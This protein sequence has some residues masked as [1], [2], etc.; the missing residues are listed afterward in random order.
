MKHWT[1]HSTRISK[2]SPHQ[3]IHFFSGQSLTVTA[4]LDYIS[5]HEVVFEVQP[6]DQKKFQA[7]QFSMPASFIQAKERKALAGGGEGISLCVLMAHQGNGDSPG[8]VWSYTRQDLNGPKSH[9]ATGI[10]L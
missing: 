6:I 2:D 8:G 1:L 3:T 9:P 10:S 7:T 5:Y 4:F